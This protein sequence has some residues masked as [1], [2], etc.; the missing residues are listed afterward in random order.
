MDH[1]DAG[2]RRFWRDS[3]DFSRAEIEELVA[4]VRQIAS[5]SGW[6]NPPPPPSSPDELRG[7]PVSRGPRPGGLSAGAA[8]DLPFEPVRVRAVA[9]L[10]DQDR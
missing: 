5:E 3:E 7:M 10:A 1:L 6:M 9:A 8:V 2:E 4:I